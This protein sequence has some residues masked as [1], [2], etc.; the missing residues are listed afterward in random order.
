MIPKGEVHFLFYV[1]LIVIRCIVKV[2]RVV[3]VLFVRIVRVSVSCDWLPISRLG[4]HHYIL[5][6]SLAKMNLPV[7]Q[8]DDQYNC[9]WEGYGILNCIWRT[10]TPREIES[11]L[12][13][14]PTFVGKDVRIFMFC[15]LV[16]MLPVG[17]IFERLTVETVACPLCSSWTWQMRRR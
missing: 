15:V 3:V 5:W 6:V 1:N 4:H 12:T 7:G 8:I 14:M 2:T 11:I 10:V 16:V 17:H 13:R 9:D